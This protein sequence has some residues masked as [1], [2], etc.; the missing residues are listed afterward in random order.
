LENESKTI[1]SVARAMDLLEIVREKGGGVGVTEI[2]R[3]IRLAKSTVYRLMET[4]LEKG[5]LS[6]DQASDKYSLGYKALELAFSASMNWSLVNF[7]MPFL[8]ELRD[9][10]NETTAL[11][12]KVGL[13]YTYI[14]EAVSNQEFLINPVLGRSYPLHWSGAGKA[15]LAY[16]GGEELNEALRIVPYSRSTPL[17]I[18]DTEVLKAQLG[19]I[20]RDGYATSFGERAQGAA[21]IAVAICD[22]KNLAI[23]AVC[24]VGP[25]SRLR[26]MDLAA[27]SE[28]IKKICHQIERSYRTLDYPI[29]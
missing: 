13:N 19:E 22:P 23:G 28:S 3:E 25:E 17:T 2:S 14:A 6:K 18:T 24:L 15:I 21:V 27:T 12:I 9:M 1:R 7:A 26:K 4:L 5:M 11:A 16:T 10:Y 20:R 29:W 8:D